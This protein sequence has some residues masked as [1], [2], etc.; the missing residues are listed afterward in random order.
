MLLFWVLTDVFLR[1]KKG[2]FML[3]LCF[4]GAWGSWVGLAGEVNGRVLAACP[5]QRF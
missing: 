1:V 3:V 2:V 5:S 4:G